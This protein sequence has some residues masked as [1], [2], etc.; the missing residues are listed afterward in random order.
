MAGKHEEA[1]LLMDQQASNAVAGWITDVDE[2]ITHNEDRSITS[3][4]EAEKEQDAARLFMYILGTVA[5]ALAI[6]ISIF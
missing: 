5:I 4:L 6:I 2:L 3:Y 1:I